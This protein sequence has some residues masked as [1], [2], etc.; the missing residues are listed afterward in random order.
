MLIFKK[1][2]IIIT[3]LSLLLLTA[4]Y[5]LLNSQNFTKYIIPKI[6]ALQMNELIINNIHIQKQTFEPKGSLYFKG[7]S[8]QLNAN[9]ENYTVNLKDLSLNCHQLL[10]GEKAH[11]TLL[12]NELNIKSDIMSLDNLTV[13]ATMMKNISI[14]EGDFSISEIQYLD[15]KARNINGILS[16]NHSSMLI[17]ISRADFY[18]GNISAE[19]T[20][21]NNVLSAYNINLIL[22]NIDIQQMEKANKAIFSNAKG[23]VDGKI[24]V[25]GSKQNPYEVTGRIFSSSNAQIKASLLEPLLRYIPQSQ[26]KKDLQV[27]LNEQGNIPLESAEI[28][29]V[30]FSDETVNTHIDLKSKKFNLDV[31]VDVDFNLEG[32]LQNL[33]DIQ[34]QYFLKKRISNEK[35]Y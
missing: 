4:I 15:Y 10:S 14:K 27:L 20:L 30:N 31:G 21:A 3:L 12:L 23:L 25:T 6:I 17:Q 9:N 34:K 2:C 11:V 5:F 7:V 28:I 24:G 26:Q 18:D 35:I 22:N 13:S 32:G 33:L 29:L 1:I 19:I 16:N 8:F